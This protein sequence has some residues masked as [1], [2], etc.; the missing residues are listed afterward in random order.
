MEDI[1]ELDVG[2]TPEAAVSGPVLLQTDNSTVLTFNAM[3][4]SDKGKLVDAGTAI[5]E[6]EICSIT[7][8]GYPNDEAWC[9]IPRTRRLTYGFYEVVNSAWK[10]EIAALNRH[11]FP[12]TE[13]WKGRHFLILF[14]DSSFE[15]IARGFKIETSHERYED[16]WTRVYQR[17]LRYAAA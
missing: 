10:S 12:E 17:V 4:K 1:V 7:K 11:S 15:C 6:F 8:F 13:E 14:H 2:C 9:G 16:L 3:C 5:V